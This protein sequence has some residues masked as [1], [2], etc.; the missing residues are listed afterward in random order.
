MR[1]RRAG[2]WRKLTTENREDREGREGTARRVRVG[3]GHFGQELGTER[4]TSDRREVIGKMTP[5]Q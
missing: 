1:A 3:N 2:H 5:L 4:R